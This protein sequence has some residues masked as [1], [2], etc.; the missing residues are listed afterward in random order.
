MVRIM[1]SRVLPIFAVQGCDFGLQSPL[2]L[3][4]HQTYVASGWCTNGVNGAVESSG[5]NLYPQTNC[6]ATDTG[7]AANDATQG[8]IS[9]YTSSSVFH[10]GLLTTAG[11]K[12]GCDPTGGSNKRSVTVNGPGGGTFQIASATLSCYLTNRSTRLHHRRDRHHRHHHGDAHCDHGQRR[13]HRQQRHHDPQSGVL[14]H[15]GDA[16]GLQR[17]RDRLL[18]R[19]PAGRPTR[20]VAPALSTS[21]ASLGARSLH[22][23]RA[24]ASRPS[25]GARIVEE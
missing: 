24:S 19:W 25:A 5:S 8:L 7:L 6:V 22:R 1:A 11:T 15:Q 18:G 10:A 17:P 9:G 3:T 20:A 2:S 16:D 4:K 13:D 12:T 21:T 23:G 14:Q